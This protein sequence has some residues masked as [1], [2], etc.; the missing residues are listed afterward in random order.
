MA[1]T[2]VDR[3][4]EQ[5]KCNIIYFI[6]TPEMITCGAKAGGPTPQQEEQWMVFARNS[7]TGSE[8]SQW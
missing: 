6:S 3:L 1:T 2:D 5:E 7:F 4:T 8:E